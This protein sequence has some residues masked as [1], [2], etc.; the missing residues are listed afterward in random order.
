MTIEEFKKNRTKRLEKL[1]E[2][3]V[4]MPDAVDDK[5]HGEVDAPTLD[6]IETS[7]E[8]EQKIKD[9]FKE[10]NKE[11]REFIKAQDKAVG[12]AEEDKAEKRLTLDEALF[13]SDGDDDYY[14][15]TW[16]EVNEFVWDK[17]DQF[18]E[19][20]IAEEV[21]ANV[22]GYNADWC[23]PAI[24]RDDDIHNLME[25]LVDALTDKLFANK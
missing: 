17:M 15:D 14:Q 4:N 8:R 7:K 10:K 3:L 21:A 22:E 24:N 1:H 9:A 19:S 11:A 16:Y 13:E 2:A 23:D 20:I 25:E 12:A 6:I 5:V 18:I